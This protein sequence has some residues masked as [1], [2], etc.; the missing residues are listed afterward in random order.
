[1]RSRKRSIYDHVDVTVSDASLTSMFPVIATGDLDGGGHFK[2]AGN[3]GPLNRED[4]SLTPLDGR[5]TIN[6]LIWLRGDFSI[7]Q[8]AL[9]ASSTSTRRRRSNPLGAL[10][11]LFKKR[12]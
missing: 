6:G 2:L 1:M 9:A 7:P 4:A 12:R 11:D 10:Q 3:V 5:L 8:S